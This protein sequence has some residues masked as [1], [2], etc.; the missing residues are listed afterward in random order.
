ACCVWATLLKPDVARSGKGNSPVPCTAWADQKWSTIPRSYLA[1]VSTIAVLVYTSKAKLA[2]F[3]AKFG[4]AAGSALPD[5]S[6]TAVPSA[7][8]I[9]P[10]R[11]APASQGVVNSPSKIQNSP[12]AATVTMGWGLSSRRGLAPAPRRWQLRAR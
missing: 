5:A 12:S 6:L 1:H 9:A 3:Y 2:Q 4:Q 7:R 10:P 8:D 11:D